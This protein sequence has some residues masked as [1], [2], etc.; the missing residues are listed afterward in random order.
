MLRWC[1]KL[2]PCTNRVDTMYWNSALTSR[3]IPCF[4]LWLE[5]QD[6]YLVPSLRPDRT[7]SSKLWSHLLD[8]QVLEELYYLVE[9]TSIIHFTKTSTA[10]CGNFRSNLLLIV[11]LH[12]E[13][14]IKLDITQVVV[15]RFL[16]QLSNIHVTAEEQLSHRIYVQ[17]SVRN[18]A[19]HRNINAWGTG[20]I[21]SN[22]FIPIYQIACVQFSAILKEKLRLRWKKKA[23]YCCVGGFD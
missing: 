18:G 20:L 14:L 13:K 7:A 3:G 21:N 9:H 11:L 22:S 8:F 5:T 17:V 23:W 12:A 2:V 15:R 16:T 1:V 10:S 19:E 4:T 6:V